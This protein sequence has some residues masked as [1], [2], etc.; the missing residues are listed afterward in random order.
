MDRQRQRAFADAC[1]VVTG[2]VHE[3]PGA[4][5]DLIRDLLARGTPT[6]AC[7][8]SHTTVARVLTYLE[9]RFSDPTMR[10]SSAARHASLSPAYLARLLKAS[11]GRTFLQHVRQLRLQH[12]ERLLLT[13]TLSI[14]EVASHCGYYATGSFD[15]NFRRVHGCSPSAWRRVLLA[16]ARRTA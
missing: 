13:P 1:Q 5:S 7:H 4:S 10:L 16:A 8:T 6:I 11:T 3:N 9:Q 2:Y 14:K 12:A 15:R